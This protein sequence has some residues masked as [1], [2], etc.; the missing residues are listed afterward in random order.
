M[1]VR[2]CIGTAPPVSG[3]LTVPASC[4][5]AA[6]ASTCTVNATW[7]TTNAT[8]PKLVDGNPGNVG[9]PALS[10]SANQLAPGLTVWVANPST[11]FNLQ[12][13]N[14]VL[15]TK[16]VAASCAPN[17][18][19]SGT[20]C[21]AN[22]AI[23]SFTPQSA[24][25]LNGQ[26]TTLVGSNITG[27]GTVTCSIDQG[28]GPVQVVS[29]NV[30]KGTGTLTL[31][32]TYTLT[33]R[34]G[35]VPDASKST[36]VAVGSAPVNG[37]C[38]TETTNAC[39]VGTSG[40][41]SGNATTYTWSCAGANGG[42]TA[43]CSKAKSA[44]TLSAS[45]STINYSES[46]T[47]SYSSSYTSSC[48]ITND[49]ATMSIAVLANTSGTTSVTPLIDTVYTLT[50]AGGASGTATV[51]VAAG[52]FDP[53]STPSSCMIPANAG[54]CPVNLTW[55]SVNFSSP[56]I[57]NGA[58]ASLYT[59]ANGTSK[60]VNVKYG[61]DTFAIKNGTF[62]H[63]SISIAASCAPN[64]TWSGTAC[65]AN[66]AIGSFTP[67]SASLLNGQNTTLVGSNITGGGTVTCS[68]DQGLGPV[69]VVSGN[70]SKGTGTLTLSTTYTLTC[71]NGV[72]QTHRSP[73]R[74]PLA[75]PQ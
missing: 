59:T 74:S 36:T 48:S 57:A 2:G 37:V 52:Q 45:P 29:G 9:A 33:C 1:E 30:S 7:T 14:T 51:L 11:V 23:G 19:W 67:Q 20:A 42:T 28:L 44:A 5:I 53:S 17:T 65:L 49:T 3:I 16:T 73:P 12:D 69:Q 47:L 58:S 32:T 18:T 6:G 71:R 75:V 54:S 72:Y 31:S 26:N 35:V 43:S 15:D 8:S 70:V 63:D 68:I 13:G 22:V 27:G 64:T 39:I 38:G 10:T 4:I 62:T 50:C 46:S 60:L 40:N 34:N 24:S 61:G 55:S 41:S 56:V 25:L 21:L 66:V